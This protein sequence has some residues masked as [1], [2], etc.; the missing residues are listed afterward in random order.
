[1][2]LH[3]FQNGLISSFLCSTATD[4]QS[5]TLPGGVNPCEYWFAL[6]NLNKNLSTYTAPIG[7][8]ECTNAGY[9]QDATNSFWYRE[10][11]WATAVR[12]VYG[13]FTRSTKISDEN[14]NFGFIGSMGTGIAEIG[15]MGLDQV[16]NGDAYYESVYG[17]ASPT[18]PLTAT[19]ATQFR[20]SAALPVDGSAT[21]TLTNSGFSR[22][23]YTHPCFYMVHITQTGTIVSGNVK[24]FL[25]ERPP[26]R[27]STLSHSILSPLSYR[28]SDITGSSTLSTRNYFHFLSRV[29]FPWTTQPL[30]LLNDDGSGSTT[31]PIA[32]NNYSSEYPNH[33]GD[34]TI[35]FDPRLRDRAICRINEEYFVVVMDSRLAILSNKEGY[36]PLYFLDM[37][38]LW[39]SDTYKRIAGVCADPSTLKIWV[40]SESGSLASLD[41]SSTFGGQFTL[42]ASAPA[43]ASG[44]R[45][46]SIKTNGSVVYA[47]YGNYATVASSIG[48][49]TP[50]LGIVTYT[51]GTNTWGSL[52][53]SGFS[54]TRINNS[55]LNDMILG[56]NGKLYIMS[57]LVTVSSSYPLAKHTDG[58]APTASSFNNLTLIQRVPFEDLFDYSHTSFKLK[59]DVVS[60]N[61]VID[62]IVIKTQAT[63][64][65]GLGAYSSSTAVS[66]GGLF[67]GITLSPGVSYSDLISL[68]LDLDGQDYTIM[69]YF[70]ANVANNSLSLRTYNSYATNSISRLRQGYFTASGN[71]TGLSTGPNIAYSSCGARFATLEGV[72]ANRVVNSHPS[73][74][75]WALNVVDPAGPTW[76]QVTSSTLLTA[77]QVDISPFYGPLFPVYYHH[78]Y[79]GIPT[80]MIDWRVASSKMIEVATDKLLIQCNWWRNKVLLFDM[81]G[82][83]GVGKITEISQG[84]ANTIFPAGTVYTSELYV[85]TTFAKQYED[86]RILCTVGD[87]FGGN[88]TSGY[89][90]AWKGF[91]WGTDTLASIPLSASGS[92]DKNYLK[93][94][95]T[96]RNYQGIT[97]SSTVGSYFAFPIGFTRSQFTLISNN[98]I[99]ASGN[100]YHIQNSSSDP[101]INFTNLF[102]PTYYKWTGSAWTLAKD[103]TDAATLGNCYSVSST[104]GTNIGIVDGLT[105]QFGPTGTNTFTSGEFHTI[106]V[107][108]GQI[109]FA[110]KAKYQWAMFAGKT[111]T[112][113]E[114]KTMA[115][116]NALSFNLLS[117]TSWT[118]SVTGPGGTISQPSTTLH[119]YPSTYTGAPNS[120]VAVQTIAFGSSINF[121]DIETR[122]A[123]CRGLFFSVS[124]D[125]VSYTPI[126][127][128]WRSYFGRY[129]SFARQTGIT[130]LRITYKTPAYYDASNFQIGDIYLYDYGTQGQIDAARLGSSG[131]SDNT[132]AR[133]SF[134]TQCLG[135]ATDAMTLSIDGASP[136]VLLPDSV[137][138]TLISN[139]YSGTAVAS[140]KFKAHPFFGFILFEGAG[141]TGVNSTK[142]GTNVSVS[143]HWGR[144]V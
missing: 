115:S 11:N 81:T 74:I 6:D 88:C 42:K 28:V 126:T 40:L 25:E 19:A 33:L 68:P 30:E 57:E 56:S 141:A 86:D 114:T 144:R 55:N 128:L 136:M 99:A 95:A 80:N 60:G 79:P 124:S 108:Y 58:T 66:V 44:E 39:S 113:T 5:L 87:Y 1:M 140:S 31:V 20:N 21:I 133:G 78:S 85:L 71:Q 120:A 112:Q 2:A 75:K 8:W 104:P 122:I 45:Y 7:I 132:A 9:G 70:A 35:W 131:A 34:D 36:T 127:P 64:N 118:S 100:Q 73:D 43:L 37:A 24:F 27:L 101:R 67:T 32:F 59:F 41:F 53:S 49:G 92:I 69:V 125:G 29:F 110:K 48:S 46:G 12:P 106:N 130:H 116:Q 51:I 72:S 98:T 143:Y 139:F 82:V 109:K 50:S 138:E 52:Q 137:S 135:I 62:A 94:T 105:I 129:R 77:N 54:N 84:S 3:P 10:D 22:S 63:G 61:P 102:V 103:W 119:R 142:T 97:T 47:C 18:W 26:Y 14:T 134:D 96:P 83:P 15:L 123:G 117:R 76:S 111:F 90:M 17:H 13:N 89:Y 65:S 4:I 121:V 93:G 16:N 38:S 107:C 91:N 23:K